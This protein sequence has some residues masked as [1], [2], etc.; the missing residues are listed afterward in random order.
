MSDKVGPICDS[1]CKRGPLRGNVNIQ[2]RDK[3][4]VKSPIHAIADY[5]IIGR[6]GVSPIFRPGLKLVRLSC[7]SNEDRRVSLCR[8]LWRVRSRPEMIIR[9]RPDFKYIHGHYVSLVVFRKQ[10]Q[11]ASETTPAPSYNLRNH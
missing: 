1:I 5:C 2:V 8:S 9:G 7:V 6:Y 11:T 3:T 10:M 4:R